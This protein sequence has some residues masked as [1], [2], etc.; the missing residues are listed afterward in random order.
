MPRQNSQLKILVVDDVPSNLRIIQTVLEA[1]YD[2]FFATDGPKALHLAHTEQ[3]DM[4]LLDIMMQNM[5]GYEV[6]RRL[7]ADPVTRAI[8]VLFISA[9]HDIMDEAKGLMLGA[10]DFILKPI[11]PILLKARIMEHGRRIAASQQ[12]HNRIEELENRLTHAALLVQKV[13]RGNSQALP[14]LMNLLGVTKP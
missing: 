2:L 11:E 14:E 9:K 6:C 8:T 10:S 12:L 4:V 5:D 13:A 3:P 1:D 7:K